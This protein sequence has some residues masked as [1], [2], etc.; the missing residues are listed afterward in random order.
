[1]FHAHQGLELLYVYE[2]YGSA[3]VERRT[4]AL[5]PGTLF[6]FQPYQLHRVEVPLQG[7]ASYVRTNLTFDPRVAERYTAPF[8]KLQAFLRKLWKGALPQQVFALA[9]DERLPQL[10]ASFE[11][12][13]R[14]AHGE[15][16]EEERGL[17][18]LALLRHLQL[19]VFPA[20]ETGAA[21]AEKASRHIEHIQDWV[22]AHYGQP[23][24]LENMAAALHLSPYHISHLFKRHT[25]VTLSDYMTNRRLREACALLANTDKQVGDIAR[26]VGGFS[27]PYFC[28]LFKKHK[29]VTPQSYRAT[30]RR[31]YER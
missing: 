5:Q 31:A 18:L 29:G 14:Q 30:V 4:Y 9:G 17:F 26:E 27:A 28:Q 6:C 21:A 10:L 13:R 20:G 15:A 3:T 16:Q 7:E 1:M 11:Q 24:E 2:G 8:P 23:F 22:E 19:H 12:A 25:G